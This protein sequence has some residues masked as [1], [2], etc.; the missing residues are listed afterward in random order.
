MRLAAGFLLASFLFSG[1]SNGC[2]VSSTL[3]NSVDDVDD[4]VFVTMPT[5]ALRPASGCFPGFNFKMPESPPASLTGW[6]CDWD[7]EY[8]FVGFSYEVSACQSLHTLK[9]EF[10]DI[11]Q[12]FHGRYVRIYGTCDR[13]GFNDDVINAAWHAGIG[14]HALIW[15]G[16]DG[17]NKWKGRRDA[18]FSTLHSNPYAKFVV[19][20]VQFGSEPLF[21]GV[22]SS[23][24]LAK[25]V[26]RAKSELAK[27]QIPVTVS[28]MAYSYQKDRA[29]SHVIDAIDIIDAHILPFFSRDASTAKKSWPLVQQ[30]LN[31]FLNNGQGKKIY[32]SQNGWPSKSYPGVEPNSDK[33]VANVQNEK[34]Y[35]NLL[36]AHCSHF[37]SAPGGGIGWFAHIYSD[38]QEP[39]YGIYD[40]KGRL[41]FPF[42]PRVTC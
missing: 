28:D 31:W 41:K 18:L 2:P 6:W 35:F 14:V 5:A 13:K 42:S 19:R 24:S 8:A 16:F 11:R 23:S 1:F 38:N 22:L 29:S 7:T 33:A 37:K 21:D 4:R 36:D 30:D 39:G 40:T 15:F 25:E 26:W 32:L 27:L 3:S 20:V 12:R 17:D 34:D 9:T 10:M